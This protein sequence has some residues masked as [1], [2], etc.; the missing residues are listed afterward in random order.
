[1]INVLTIASSKAVARLFFGTVGMR[2]DVPMEM[3]ICLE[4]Q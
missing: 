3:D 1:M 4:W 2:L